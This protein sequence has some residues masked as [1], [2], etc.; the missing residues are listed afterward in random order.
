M[1]QTERVIN[2]LRLRG[3]RGLTPLEAQDLVGT[4]RLA[5]RIADAKDLIRNDEEIVTERYTTPN[6]AVVARY[7]L[8]P[9]TVRGATPLTLWPTAD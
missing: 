4:M 6:G 1:T 9:R 7:V 3:D 5:A 2:L 8:R